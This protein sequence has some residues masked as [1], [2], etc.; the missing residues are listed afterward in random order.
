MSPRPHA[1]KHIAFLIEWASRRPARSEEDVREMKGAQVGKFMGTW[2]HG[3]DILCFFY[4]D[5]A[6]ITFSTPDRLLTAQATKEMLQRGYKL[7]STEMRENANGRT[8][9]H[10]YYSRSIKIA[11]PRAV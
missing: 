4:G 8:H 9:W 6:V 10:Y 7:A 5:E 2:H 1:P 3:V 11:V